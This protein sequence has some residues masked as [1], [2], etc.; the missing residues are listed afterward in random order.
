MKKLLVLLS[1][2]VLLSLSFSSIYL[3]NYKNN[4]QV[5]LKQENKEETDLTK[6][7]NRGYVSIILEDMSKLK[8]K[9]ISAIKAKYNFLNFDLLD[10]QVGIL[11]NG[12]Q[13]RNVLIK[14]KD[15]VKDNKY[16]NQE[17]IEYYIKKDIAKELEDFINLNTIVINTESEIL[18]TISEKLDTTTFKQ[19]H[20][21]VSNI[22]ESTA[23]INAKDSNDD[24]YGKVEVKFQAKKKTLSSVFYNFE[25][26]S[27][28]IKDDSDLLKY[29][30]NKKP[31]LAKE[32]LSVEFDFSKSS[33]T[34]MVD[35]NS[36]NYDGNAIIKLKQSKS[37]EKQKTDKSMKDF[38]T[39]DKLETEITPKS[40]SKVLSKPIEEK[41][42]KDMSDIKK[43]ES[44]KD[45]NIS[46]KEM[47]SESPSIN[48]MS[49]PEPS[50]TLE[51]NKPS[52][53]II[54]KSQ[55]KNSDNKI[56]SIPNNTMNKSNKKST[57]SKTGVIV[58][59]TLGVGSVVG[60]GAAGSWI[61][62]K[63]RK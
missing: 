22:T 12:R 45:K 55:N 46:D 19:K 39:E 40:P 56:P 20:F 62:F 42:Q 4:N 11:K 13:T 43:E 29:I 57:G 44:P 8:E 28:D 60:I 58:G 10:I 63:R 14:P 30:H 3:L 35:N 47:S 7:F 31:L 52:T 1:S 27:T 38:K 26:D 33:V 51:P 25:V 16:K 32:K 2:S 53:P 23:I 15:S 49:I 24:F 9:V 41:M 21:F 36:S 17:E 61:Y 37:S 48:E 54:D 50:P 6:I 34:I 18:K 59:S 5:V